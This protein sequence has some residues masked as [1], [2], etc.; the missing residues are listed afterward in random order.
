MKPFAP[1]IIILSAITLPL[2]PVTTPGLQARNA[3]IFP[4]PLRGCHPSSG[5]QPP[6]RVFVA[7]DNGVAIAM[8]PTTHELDARTPYTIDHRASAD[9]N[10]A[11]EDLILAPHEQCRVGGGET[12]RV[13]RGARGKTRRPRPGIQHLGAAAQGGIEESAA[14]GRTGRG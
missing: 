11:V 9:K 6:Q 5:E 3:S 13:Q 4:A 7:R 10:P 1:R 8:P 14:R 12:H 2:R